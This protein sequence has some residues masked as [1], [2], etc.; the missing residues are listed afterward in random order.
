MRK[1]NFCKKYANYAKVLFN[2]EEILKEIQGKNKEQNTKTT[3]KQQKQEQQVQNNESSEI[4]LLLPSMNKQLKIIR[5]FITMLYIQ[6]PIN[7]DLM[8]KSIVKMISTLIHQETVDRVD[9]YIANKLSGIP[10]ESVKE[11]RKL[12]LLLI[13]E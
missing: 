7:L 5:S 6:D 2:K 1:N 8:K 13:N 11:K 12:L 10:K 3:L 4:L 9:R